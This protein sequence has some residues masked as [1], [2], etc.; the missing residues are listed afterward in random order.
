MRIVFVFLMFLSTL[1]SADTI[2][3][4]SLLELFK[5]NYYSYICMH[6]WKYINKYERKNEKLLS[7]V[8][9]AC[10]KKHYLTPALDLAKVLRVTKIGR[11]NATYITTLFLIKLL[12]ERYIKDNYPI[13][14][15]KIPTIEG[16]LL[17]KVFY[18]AQKQKPLVKDN[19]FNVKEG[20]STYNVFFKEDINNIII[21]I[22]KNGNFVKKEKYW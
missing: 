5:E 16:S 8:A 4:K 6:R 20:N 15:I 12:T 10:L 14:D 2:K 13:E 3:N 1:F 7:V 19:S 21:S 9:Y 17:A 18:L 11:T 22:Y